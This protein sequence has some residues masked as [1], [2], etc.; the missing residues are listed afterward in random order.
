MTYQSSFPSLWEVGLWFLSF[1]I[2]ASLPLVDVPCVCA[3]LATSS[4]VLVTCVLSFLSLSLVGMFVLKIKRT[5][6]LNTR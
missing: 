6:K 1:N 4:F 3:L 2:L 5:K